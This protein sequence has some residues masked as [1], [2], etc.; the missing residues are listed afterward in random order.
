MARLATA[1]ALQLA[2]L[3]LA[4]QLVYLVRYGSRFGEELVHAG[5]GDVWAFAVATSTVLG[6]GLVVAG[7][8]RLAY[9]TAIVRRA[10]GPNAERAGGPLAATALQRAWLRLAPRMAVVAAVLLT[11]QENLERASVG[12]AMPGPGVLL[13]SEYPAGLWITIAVAF[14]VSFVAALFDWRRGVLL[15]HLSRARTARHRRTTAVPR[16]PVVRVVRPVGS[17]IGR[18]S[19]LR[20]PP[21]AASAA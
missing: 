16:R 3:V 20:A 7:A 15:A 6:I 4:H 11:V 14:V 8:A 19:A 1:G 21:I 17:L 5:H 18:G 13:S 12:Q 10:T 2:A 9:L